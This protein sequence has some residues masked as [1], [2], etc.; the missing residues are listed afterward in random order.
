MLNNAMDIDKYFQ[1]HPD[2]WANA[3][4]LAQHVVKLALLKP[5]E[6]VDLIV[7]KY[8]RETSTNGPEW[9]HFWFW[10]KVENRWLAVGNLSGAVKHYTANFTAYHLV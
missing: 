5:G 3:C 6:T 1:K 9:D 4:I 8:M 10:D 2:R 7:G